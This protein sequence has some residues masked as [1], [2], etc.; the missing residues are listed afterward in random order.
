MTKFIMLIACTL[1]IIPIF[2]FIP[3]R[4]STKNKLFLSGLSIVLAIGGLY[5]ADRLTYGTSVGAM[6]CFAFITAYIIEK[7]M[8]FLQINSKTEIRINIPIS[9][10]VIKTEQAA[11]DEDAVKEIEEISVQMVDLVIPLKEEFEEAPISMTGDER[12]RDSVDRED[13]QLLDE[14]FSFLQEGR[15][16]LSDNEIDPKENFKTANVPPADRFLLFEEIEE[17][18]GQPEVNKIEP[19]SE[20]IEIV[21]V[22]DDN[23]HDKNLKSE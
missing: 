15:E 9:K 12:D 16:E 21:N 20:M 5:V 10:N 6:L 1:I 8:P 23:P 19:I 11:S 22:I 14:D 2:Y 4:L 17:I 3:L 13:V 7:R 18:A